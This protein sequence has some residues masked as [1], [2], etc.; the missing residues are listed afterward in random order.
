MPGSRAP[1]DARTQ[2]A[3][4]LASPGATEDAAARRMIASQAPP[5]VAGWVTLSQVLLEPVRKLRDRRDDSVRS[6]PTRLH[7]VRTELAR[8]HQ[9]GLH[10]VALRAADVRV[11]VVTDHPGQAGIGVERL[12]SSFEVGGRGLAEHDRLDVGRVLES[13]DE[14][15]GVEEWPVLRLPPAVLVQAGELRAPLELVE[16]PRPVHVS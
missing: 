11:D 12:E 4:G 10:P 7:G 15:A 13:G 2:G 5:N 9:H 16:G 14:G 6:D 8:S 3:L 1:S